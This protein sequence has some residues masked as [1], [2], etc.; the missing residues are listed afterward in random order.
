MLGLLQ[1]LLKELVHGTANMQKATAELLNSGTD[2]VSIATGA[3][4]PDHIAGLLTQGGEDKNNLEIFLNSPLVAST[5]GG[6][7]QALKKGME[8]KK[9]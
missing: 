9:S 5:L 7:T 1:D 6:L 3:G 2:A 4:L 8:E